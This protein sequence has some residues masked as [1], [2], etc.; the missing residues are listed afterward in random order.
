MPQSIFDTEAAESPDF[1]DIRARLFANAAALGDFGAA[2]SS[3]KSIASADDVIFI[4]ILL[5]WTKPSFPE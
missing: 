4:R 5:S 3:I 2:A 1:L